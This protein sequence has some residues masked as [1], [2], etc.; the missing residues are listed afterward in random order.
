VLEVWHRQHAQNQALT[1]TDPRMSRFLISL[2]QACQVVVDTVDQML[3]GEIFIPILPATTMG[4]L[5]AALYGSNHP[6]ETI[7]IRPGGEKS[8]ES[9]LSREER[10]RVYKH[11]CGLWL[12][13]PSFHS[14]T[15]DSYPVET[16]PE[17]DS[18]TEPHLTVG[19]TVEW[20]RREGIV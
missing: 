12:V 16:V 15:S 5:A 2:R 20:L 6:W 1:L 8:H 14:W 11:P 19:E 4:T 3:G 17:Y 9:L 7:G 13:A 18:D 10:H